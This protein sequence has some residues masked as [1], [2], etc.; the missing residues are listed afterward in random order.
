MN[1]SLFLRSQLA[2]NNEVR[3]GFCLGASKMNDDRDTEFEKL[4]VLLALQSLLDFAK[5]SAD[6]IAAPVLSSALDDAKDAVRSSI[7]DLEL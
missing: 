4:E 3:V 6:E 7:D 2:F 5:T 1:D